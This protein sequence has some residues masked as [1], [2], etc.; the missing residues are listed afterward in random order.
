MSGFRSINVVST[1]PIHGFMLNSINRSGLAWVDVYV[2][3]RRVIIYN[4]S[5]HIMRLIMF[6][7]MFRDVGP[8]QHLAK[9]TS[10][11]HIYNNETSDQIATKQRLPN[12]TWRFVLFGF[13]IM[14]SI[15]G[16]SFLGL[17]CLS[18]SDHLRKL[19]V[20]LF[21]LSWEFFLFIFPSIKCTYWWSMV[22]I[23]FLV[24][25]STRTKQ[26]FILGLNILQCFSIFKC[27]K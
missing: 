17:L 1:L 10:W 16:F 8:N 18:I 9:Q 12:W 7:S 3:G 23:C 14:D 19:L 13:W 25:M 5:L 24:F 11:K 20:F 26:M 4:L 21:F 6:I 15:T 27:K 22:I 2:V